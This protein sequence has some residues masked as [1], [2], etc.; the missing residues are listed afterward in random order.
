MD[1]PTITDAITSLVT[2][3]TG[4]T[5]GALGAA[6]GLVWRKGLTWRD[7]FTQLAVGI[8][9]SWFVTRA[10]GAIWRLDPFVLQAISFTTGMIAFEATPRFIAAASDVVASLPT[11]LRDRLVGKV[12]KGGDQ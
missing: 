7:R 6:V 8:I 10:L 11:I 3:A 12:D 1:K 2:I 5:P 4:L 9:V